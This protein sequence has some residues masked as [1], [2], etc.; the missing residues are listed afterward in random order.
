M[1]TVVRRVSCTSVPPR[2]HRARSR[3]HPISVPFSRCPCPVTRQSLLVSRFT[4][5]CATVVTKT[6]SLIQSVIIIIPA[7]H[8]PYRDRR[9]YQCYVFF[10]NQ[11]FFS[12]SFIYSYIHSFPPPRQVHNN[13]LNPKRFCA[14]LQGAYI[15]SGQSSWYSDRVR[16]RSTYIFIYLFSFREILC[17]KCV[18][19]YIRSRSLL[20][21]FF[22]RGIY[23][24][25]CVFNI[26]R[27]KIQHEVTKRIHF[28]HASDYFILFRLRSYDNGLIDF[29]E[30]LQFVQ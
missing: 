30:Y 6:F 2:L 13:I 12:H 3:D 1:A 4:I 29:G 23:T 28:G 15:F 25:N 8:Y 11:T 20:I 27:T 21:A 5:A 10:E 24:N 26:P 18:F 14:R 9:F 16:V 22:L 7:S 17:N 19:L